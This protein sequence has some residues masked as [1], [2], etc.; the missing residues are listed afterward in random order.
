MKLSMPEPQKK[1]RLF[2]KLIPVVLILIIALAGLYWL[3]TSKLTLHGQ[4]SATILPVAPEV[5][6]RV[7]RV[8]V[9]EGERVVAGQPLVLFESAALQ[10]AF[11]REQQ[12]LL[13]LE[14]AIPPQL[15][16]RENV[17]E[18]SLMQRLEQ[19]QAQ[20]RDALLVF[21]DMAAEDARAAVAMR[22]ATIQRNEGRITQDQYREAQDAHARALGTREAARV[23]HEKKSLARSAAETELRRLREATPL[24]P[25]DEANAAMLVKTYEA[26][27]V[28]TQA[29]AAALNAAVLR[30]P[31]A[32][33]VTAIL[34][35]PGAELHTGEAALYLIPTPVMY[36][37]IAHVSSGD[38]ATL[39]IG[40]PCSV[41]ISGQGPF[42]GLVTG[43]VPRSVPFTRPANASDAA[44]A[45]PEGTKDAAQMD[46]A[47]DIATLPFQ[48]HVR[49]FPGS[50]PLA[51][52]QG[53]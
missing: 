31:T 10:E 15:L 49:F 39:R 34:T 25:E 33:M 21:N 45:Q 36:A 50:G 48:V 9:Q 42:E 30:A 4:V 43:V 44:S 18:E 46:A 40:Q 8:A 22:R 27:A 3:S 14:A 5:S 37:A 29:A 1:S 23:D 11:F 2:R 26:Q 51:S 6:S 35:R 41:T 20:E 16:R 32:G 24:S 7:S 19:A 53:S 38:A 47:K 12:A 28:R 52:A 13:Q 17:S